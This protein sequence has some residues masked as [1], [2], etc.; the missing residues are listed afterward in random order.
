MRQV[1][2]S[3]EPAPAAETKR[4]T[5]D[6]RAVWVVRSSMP[7]RGADGRVIGLL[8]TLVDVTALK[9]LDEESR[10]LA[11]VRE[12]ELIAM[13]LHDGLIQTLY[14]LVL[15]L[16]AQEQSVDPRNEEALAAIKMARGEVEGVI[17]ETRTFLYDLRA[18]QVPARS[19]DSGLRL[20]AD[21]LRLNAGIQTRV[22]LDPALSD[23]LS[24]DVRGHLLLLAR[25]AVSNVLR[26]SHASRARIELTREADGVRLKVADNGCG[27]SVPADADRTHRGL[28]NMA[29][30]ARLVGGHLEV[31]SHNRRGTRILLDVPI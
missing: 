23:Q 31:K 3:G 27:F 14:A 10:A 25:E 12:R 19:L 2:D 16:A 1:F 18:R 22:R 30:R 24:P 4:V 7:V 20:L 26:H 28:R 29:E 21:A 11:Q 9:Q 17:D 15:N 13:D 8:D 6:G 5:R